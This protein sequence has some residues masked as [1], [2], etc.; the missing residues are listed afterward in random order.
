MGGVNVAAA[1]YNLMYVIIIMLPP[2][3]KSLLC[4]YCT[5]CNWYDAEYSL[6]CVFIK[7]KIVSHYLQDEYHKLNAVS[8]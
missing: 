2:Y 8:W 5:V 4:I 7:L 6:N 3:C 1:I